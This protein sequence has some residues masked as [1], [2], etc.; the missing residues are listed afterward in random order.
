[1]AKFRVGIPAH[2]SFIIEAKSRED[3]VGKAKSWET[4]PTIRVKLQKDKFGTLEFGKFVVGCD[5]L[6]EVDG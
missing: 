2:V 5:P 3:A 1:M 6:E 4:A